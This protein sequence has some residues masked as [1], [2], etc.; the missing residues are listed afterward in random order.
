MTITFET[1]SDVI[2]YALEKIIA[3]AK[4]NKYLF[5]ANC[6]WWLAAVTGLDNGLINYIDNLYE[7]SQIEH[8]NSQ[9]ISFRE[10]SSTPR[11]IAR[12]SSEDPGL[13]IIEEEILATR[14]SDTQQPKGNLRINPENRVKKLSKRQRR[15]LARQNK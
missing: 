7:R 12:S 8:Q 4:E 1:N 6:A 14:A 13:R 3:F 9:G 5:V 11:D 10:I 15:K 2:V